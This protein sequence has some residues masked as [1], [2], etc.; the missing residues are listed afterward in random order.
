MTMQEREEI[1]AKEYL[2]VSDFCKLYD[3]TQSQASVMMNKIRNKLTIGK[4]QEL[5]MTER[6]RL[7]V[8]DYLDW[9]GVTESRYGRKNIEQEVQA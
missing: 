4:G 5:R 3:F 8:Q 1:F 2:S 6:G 7:H 9:M